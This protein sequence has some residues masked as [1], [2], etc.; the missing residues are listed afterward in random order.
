MHKVPSRKKIPQATLNLF[1][2]HG[3]IL[4]GWDEETAGSCLYFIPWQ[5][6]GKAWSHRRN[7]CS[8]P[9]FVVVVRSLCWVILQPMN[10]SVLGFSVLHY[11]PEFAEAHVHYIG[12]AIQPSHPLM[13]PSPPALNLS[14]LQGLSQCQLFVSSSQS[15]GA[16]T[17]VLPVNIQGWFPLGLSGLISLQ[18]KGLS[19]VFSTT[20]VWK[21]QF[22][23][24]QAFLWFNSHICTRLLEKP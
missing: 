19:R 23:C 3:N 6:P 21:H 12:D 14:Q 4:L 10:C 18:S 9:K 2:A 15:I 11:L 5:V 17:S 8:F 13:L 1:Q 7:L 24:V 16:S 22:F 20:T